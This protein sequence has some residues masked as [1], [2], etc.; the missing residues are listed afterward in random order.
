MNTRLVACSNPT[1]YNSHKKSAY[2]STMPFRNVLL[3]LLVVGLF[4][5]A[6]APTPSADVTPIQQL[7]ILKELKPDV[8]RVGIVWSS[9]RSDKD[10]LL[11][12]IQQAATSTGVEIFL[13]EA[14]AVKDVAPKFRNLVDKHSIQVLWIVGDDGL[15]D[16]QVVR[17]YLVKQATK[18]LIPILAPNADWITAG[19][20]VALTRA[21]GSTGLIVNRAA[22]EAMALTIPPQYEERTSYL[23]TS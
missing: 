20:S 18:S 16:Q 17:T 22:A 11:K 1:R 14:G 21:D 2:E 3:A 7:F 4:T 19:A 10:V 13:A 8:K 5:G 23:A 15:V 12:K 6:A 9:D